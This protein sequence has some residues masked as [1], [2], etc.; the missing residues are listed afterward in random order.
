MLQTVES[1]SLKPTTH[2]NGRGFGELRVLERL[3]HG[4]TEGPNRV[5]RAGSCARVRSLAWELER[6][7]GGCWE[8]RGP[9]GGACVARCEAY[10]TRT[11]SEGLRWLF[12]QN[13]ETRLP[14][15]EETIA[16]AFVEPEGASSLKMWVTTSLQEEPVCSSSLG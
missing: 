13:G 2:L 3:L 14:A 7:L 4:L 8:R 10:A 6:R 11:P 16:V 9:R 12:E 1:C 15:V 5:C